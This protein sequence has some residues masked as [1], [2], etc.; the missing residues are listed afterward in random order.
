MN[1]ES[2]KPPIQLLQTAPLFPVGLGL[3]LGI[4]LDQSAAPPGLA[5]LIALAA[6]TAVTLLAPIRRRLG[7]LCIL[8]ASIATGGLLHLSS[9]RVTPTDSVEHYA[10]ETGQLARLRGTV[11]LEPRLLPSPQSPFT[12][13]THR[14]N[15]TGFLLDVESIAGEDGAIS[16]TGYVRV[17]VLEPVLDLGEGDRVELFGR[18]YALRPRDNPGSFDW[19]RYSRSQGIVARIN[20]KHREAIQRIG[21]NDL[22]TPASL[23]A[24]V[25]QRLRHLL[26][27]GTTVDANGTSGLLEG[28]I[29]GQRSKV[30]RLLNELF[31]KAGCVHFLAVSGVHLVIVMLLARIVARAFGATGRV[32]ILAMMAAIIF[33]AVIAEPRPPILRASIIGMIYCVACLLHRQRSRLNWISA[34][35]AVL[36]IMR[37]AMIFDVGYQLSTTAVLGVSYLAP[38][39]RPLVTR[40]VNGIILMIERVFRVELDTANDEPN[41]PAPQAHW[42]RRVYR[43]TL[44]KL[45]QGMSISLAAWL[46]ALPVVAVV[47]FRVHPWGMLSSLLLLPFVTIVMALGFVKMAV[48]AISP[49]GGAYLASLL[50]WISGLLVSCV[51]GF[52]QLP[53]SAITVAKPPMPLIGLYYLALVLFVLAAKKRTIR[54]IAENE[55]AKEKEKPVFIVPRWTSHAA[56]AILCIGII[57]WVYPVGDSGR[58]TVTVLSVGRGSATVIEL[59]NGHTLLYD[60]GSSYATD[61]GTST[62][63]PFLLTRGI[64]RIDRVY[65]SHPNLDHFSGVPTIAESIAT[66]SVVINHLFEPRAKP[67][68]PSRQLLSIL[69]N[70]DHPDYTDY[71][72]HPVETLP[73]APD[74]WRRGDVTIEYLWPTEEVGNGYTTNDTSTV[75]KLTYAGKSILLPGDIEKAAQQALLDRGG[76]AADILCLP[77]HGSVVRTT[78]A[79]IEAVNPDVLI[80][81]SNER[82]SETINT[83]TEIA[84]PYRLLNTA[85]VGA[86][87]I[88]IDAG[89]IAIATMH[90]LTPESYRD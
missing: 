53:G 59:P 67:R 70:P 8:V 9:D 66:G 87:E 72:N 22:T 12:S 51:D 4:V 80:R 50:D 46:A 37:P 82:T 27:D 1:N 32:R 86:I 55:G 65:V 48:A 83:L 69:S 88:V 57:A 47:F 40:F 23:L 33:Y 26:V 38:T 43:W 56:F 14:T 62:I 74:S 39:L 7:F 18:L 3:V 19:K 2:T 5:Y 36:A 64:T 63:V 31:I 10:T 44:W 35:I 49:T 68:S 60:A 6:A 16:A 85:D 24:T 79:F 71:I 76:L 81:S 75:L 90:N 15:R 13:W 21:R 84:R 30:S 28:M 45:V 52:S 77:H 11:V 34:C 29:L 41:S 20:C 58:L 17:T 78:K 61:P 54:T 73:A 25:R 42:A 89:G